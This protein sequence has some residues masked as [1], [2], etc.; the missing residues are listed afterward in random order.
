MEGTRTVEG[1]RSVERALT[2]LEVIGRNR[3]AGCRLADVVAGTGLQK[4]T[5]HRLI[6]TLIGVGW[7]EQEPDSGKLYLGLPVAAL[8]IAASD[9]HG[10]LELANGHLVR[11][12]EMTGDTIYL[13]VRSGFEAL[14]V[15]RVTGSF[16]I[17]TL[18]LR[19]GD[20]RPLGAGA[21]SLA[22]LSAL[23]D[24]EV[25]LVLARAGDQLGRYHF[26][27]ASVLRMMKETR[28]QGYAW[29]PGMLLPGMSA[30]GV[31]VVGSD[32]RCAA[33]L[34]VA[35]IS[36]RMLPER[37]AQIVEWL[38]KEASE[39]AAEIES[40]VGEVTEARVRRLLP[41]AT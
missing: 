38:V 9:R 18:T 24:E 16:P 30:I 23:P 13:S 33:A 26:D 6:A 41:D 8:G 29:N 35:A 21:G 25:D 19:V 15:D 14:C 5:A 32:G 40:L 36:D 7:V 37:T 1:T 17:R 22:L 10:L 2:V 3:H 11:L 20:R 12:A 39:L 31:P 34:S 27:R 28:E 4:S